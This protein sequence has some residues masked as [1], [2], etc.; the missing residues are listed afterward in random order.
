MK[1]ER[2]NH[3]VGE[4][5]KRLFTM[6]CIQDCQRVQAPP[7]PVTPAAQTNDH[8]EGTGEPQQTDAGDGLVRDRWRLISA[9][10]AWPTSGHYLPQLVDY[11]H[12]NGKV[13][14]QAIAFVNDKRPD[15]MWNHSIDSRDIAGHIENGSWS[16]SG[17]GP[18]GVDADLVVD[19]N[20]DA[21]AASGLSTGTLR[22]GSIGLDMVCSP[23]HPDMDEDLFYQLQGQVVDNKKVR[24]LPEEIT[25]VRHMALV[26]AG[27]GADP[28]SGPLKQNHTSA[29]PAELNKPRGENMKVA[30][31][32]AQGVVSALGM[33][34]VIVVDNEESVTSIADKVVQKVKALSGIDNRFNKLVGKIEALG[35]SLKKED[36]ADLSADEIVERLPG[37]VQ[38]AN[39][40]AKLVDFKRA[41]ALEWFDKA[42]FKADNGELT[43]I[44]KRLRARI[45]TIT[46]LD[47]L[48]DLIDD[49]KAQAEAMF[50]GSRKVSG[51]AELDNAKPM[52]TPADLDIAAS[53]G[54][55]FSGADKAK[56]G[57]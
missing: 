5:G 34:H 18:A 52:V 10:E 38:L 33:S 21:K 6:N 14:K 36:E 24:W 4:G 44:E 46:D 23:S 32:L 13:L 11:T 26:A 48:G 41:E 25:N 37:V 47:H 16:N 56:K 3:T 1:L 55:M 40:G 20:F 28:H 43:D 12:N 45:E 49:Y 53:V 29:K 7:N 22:A 50:P 27:T 8:S 57:E 15:L 42:K 31:D 39:Q 17:G 54:R 19:P 2:F 9:V 51:E 30:V 35:A